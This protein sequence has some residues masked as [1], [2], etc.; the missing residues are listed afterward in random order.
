[1]TNNQFIIKVSNLH[2][3]KNTDEEYDL[4]AHG[5]VFLQI[6]Y[7]VVSN[8]HTLDVT[9]SATALYL[10]RS[11]TE[12]LNEHNHDSQLIPCCGHFMYFDENERLVIGGCPSG[13][14]WTIEHINDTEIKH[15]SDKG[16]EVIINK[17]EYREIVYA[18]AD[19]VQNFYRESKSKILPTD[20][21]SRDGYL[22]F[23]K[24]WNRL[25][26]K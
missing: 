8:E 20:E 14:D 24:E 1:M 19:E 13:I 11:L 7:E 15:T 22:G 23:W 9:V 25:R 12:N 4:C 16:T 17:D 6:G 26:N 3:I 18:F 21:F 2:W 10:L 5:D